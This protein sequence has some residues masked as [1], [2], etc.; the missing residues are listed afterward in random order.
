VRLSD[1]ALAMISLGF[2]ISF[3]VVAEIDENNIL[4]PAYLTPGDNRLNVTNTKGHHGLPDTSK[5]NYAAN[6]LSSETNYDDDLSFQPDCD[7]KSFQSGS[8]SFCS[9]TQQL[10]ILDQKNEYLSSN[11]IETNS[12]LLSLYDQM[13]NL[14]KRI[15]EKIEKEQQFLYQVISRPAIQHVKRTQQLLTDQA[16]IS[17]EIIDI[18]TN[19]TALQENLQSLSGK[20]TELERESSVTT[21]ASTSVPPMLSASSVSPQINKQTLLVAKCLFPTVVT[22]AAIVV[23]MYLYVITTRKFPI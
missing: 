5:I 11:L 1:T 7:E 12:H 22:V 9:D 8:K 15:N 6:S 16:R 21:A 19:I 18:K 13:K 23:N 10:T 14:E 3:P 20:L 2:I 4:C 17:L